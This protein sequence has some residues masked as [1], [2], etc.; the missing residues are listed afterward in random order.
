MCVSG[1]PR[2]N[3]EKH[4]EQIGKMALSL[5]EVIKSYK[6]PHKPNVKMQIRVGMNSGSVMSGVVGIKMPR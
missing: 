3:G 1:L 2:T 4:V 6:I 5:I